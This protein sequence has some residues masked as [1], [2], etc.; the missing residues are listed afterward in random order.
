MF[1]D[2]TLPDP[3]V[4]CLALH[5]QTDWHSGETTSKTEKQVRPHIGCP[6]VLFSHLLGGLSYLPLAQHP[7]EWH[8]YLPTYLTPRPEVKLLSYYE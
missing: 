2:A 8:T 4:F 6:C 5:P 3:L 7:A 1:L